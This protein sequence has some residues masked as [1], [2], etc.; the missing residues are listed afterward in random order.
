MASVEDGVVLPTGNLAKC[1]GKGDVHYYT[2]DG[3]KINFQGICKYTLVKP[4]PPEEKRGVPEFNVEV[5]I[6]LY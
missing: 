2:F 1:T 5:S 3:K 6:C 4:C